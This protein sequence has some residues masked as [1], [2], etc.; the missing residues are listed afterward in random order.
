MPP[1]LGRPTPST[2]ELCGPRSTGEKFRYGGVNIDAE[3]LQM[4]AE[5]T[6]G[7]P[8]LIQ[9]VGYYVWSHVNREGRVVNTQE[10][11]SGIQ[12][13]RRRMGAAVLQ[14]AYSV[15]S[16][17]EQSYLLAMAADDGTSGTA[18]SAKPRGVN[19]VYND[20]DRLTLLAAGVRGAAGRSYVDFAVPIFR[21]FQQESPTHGLRLHHP[22]AP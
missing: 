17:V 1:H 15:L 16:T 19:T 7:Y 6:D 20:Q 18:R 10:L 12:K 8:L 9:M 11:E 13:A 4:I 3:H 14:S 22:G 2:T 21:E 5:T